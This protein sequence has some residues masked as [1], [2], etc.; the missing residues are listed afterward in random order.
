MTLISS[1]LLLHLLSFVYHLHL[2]IL[3]CLL[4][5]HLRLS[6]FLLFHLN[7]LS[8]QW[9]NLFNSLQT[10]HICY[11]SHFTIIKKCVKIS[12]C[13]K[14]MIDLLLFIRKVENFVKGMFKD[15]NTV[16][17]WLTNLLCYSGRWLWSQ[18]LILQSSLKSFKSQSA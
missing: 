13:W 14:E 12:Y 5:L 9:V 1:F 11:V 17:P 2:C 18:L 10:D 15:V 8:L 6:C 4:S 16:E 3:L 7:V